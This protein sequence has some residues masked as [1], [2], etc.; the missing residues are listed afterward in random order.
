MFE[1]EATYWWFVAR[2]QL[3][4]ELVG[5]LSEPHSSRHPPPLKPPSAT[6]EISSTDLGLST[7]DFR[8]SIRA[9]KPR[10]R[11]LDAGC[12]TGVNLQMLAKHGDAIGV[13]VSPE[14]LK[15]STK[16]SVGTLLNGRIERLGFH[17]ESFGLITAL[18]VLEHV[19]DD[20]AAIR[21]LHRITKPGGR[22]VITVPAYQSLWSEH[23]E[24]LHHYRRY[25]R[26]QLRE[27]LTDAGFE[28]EK[29]SYFMTLFFLPIFVFRLGQRLLKKRQGQAQVSYIILPKWLN[30]LLVKILDIER[31]LLR[32]ITL[33]FG[34]SLLCVAR[35][36]LTQE[37]EVV[38]FG[39]WERIG[40][41]MRQ[42]RWNH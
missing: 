14:A 26:R 24:A 10:C 42:I 11:I 40:L 23:D 22:L 5:G 30:Q 13:D 8:P 9:E 33:P 3:I 1:V 21:E 29:M 37:V 31:W 32:W 18:D 6:A 39:A 7:L 25:T 34:V 19:E 36:P 28:I 35:K 12:G 16:R 27:K 38:S 41:P 2:R 17:A 4:D 15:F 20:R